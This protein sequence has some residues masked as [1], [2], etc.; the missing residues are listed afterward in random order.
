MFL[1][2]ITLMIKCQ[3]LVRGK[4]H[5]DRVRTAV[6]LPGGLFIQWIF[7]AQSAVNAHDYRAGH[8]GDERDYNGDHGE[9]F[10]EEHRYP[11]RPNRRAQAGEGEKNQQEHLERVL[12]VELHDI[13]GDF[14]KKLH[15][16][17]PSV[18]NYNIFMIIVYC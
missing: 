7:I 6:A 18:F 17:S 15:A 11:E 8:C 10:Q 9:A 3:I 1:T 5:N 2:V 16:H 13:F 12:L 14:E 4:P